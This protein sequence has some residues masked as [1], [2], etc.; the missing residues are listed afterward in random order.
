M[1]ILRIPAFKKDKEM[2][3]TGKISLYKE[4]PQI[5]VYSEKQLVVK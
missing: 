4:K 5:V 1:T 3:I 2:C